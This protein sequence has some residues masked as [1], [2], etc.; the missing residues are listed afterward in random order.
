MTPPTKKP[1]TALVAD[2]SHAR[3]LVLP[4]GRTPF[5]ELADRVAAVETRLDE[6]VATSSASVPE[7]KDGQ[8]A[9]AQ[10]EARLVANAWPEVG[11]WV[12]VAADVGGLAAG[13]VESVSGGRIT[14][15]CGRYG[16]LVVPTNRALAAPEGFGA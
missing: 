16:V 14:V 12:V 2:T 1:G 13:R 9:F 4:S 11:A 6:I 5:L 3:P 8:A 15:N 10:L 7:P